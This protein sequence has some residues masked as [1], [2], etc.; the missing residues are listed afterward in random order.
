ML[1]D[2]VQSKPNIDVV[3]LYKSEALS[4]EIQNIGKRLEASE[5]R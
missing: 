4:S 3:K 5:S 1:K 2:E